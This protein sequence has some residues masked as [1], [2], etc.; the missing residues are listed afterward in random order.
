MGVGEW[1]LS[2]LER[3][4]VIVVL[5]DLLMRLLFSLGAVFRFITEVAARD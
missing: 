1:W 3:E 4:R 2:V 5:V